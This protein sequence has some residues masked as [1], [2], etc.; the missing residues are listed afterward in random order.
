MNQS[1]VLTVRRKKTGQVDMR[2]SE[3]SAEGEGGQKEEQQQQQIEERRK[4]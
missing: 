4:S 2:E 1:Q 3:S